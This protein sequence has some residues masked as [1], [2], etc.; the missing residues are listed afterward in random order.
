MKIGIMTFWESQNNYG[1]IL[2]ILALQTFLEQNG[3]EAFVIRYKRSASVAKK[4][5]ILQK[6]K[7]FDVQ[8]FISNR[9]HKSKRAYEA[10][11][12]PRKFDAFKAQYLKFGDTEYK[13]LGQ[14]VETPP[15][16]DVYISGSDQVWNN[17]FSVSCEAFLLGF[18]AAKTKRLSYAASFGKRELDAGTVQ[19]FEQYIHKF[20]GISVR[21]K[22]G[23]DICNRLGVNNSVWVP[24]P[25]LLFNKEEWL[26][27]LS[28]Q[29]EG[30]NQKDGNVLLYTLGNSP[31]KSKGK[32]VQY[33]KDVAGENVI[34]VS[35]NEDFAGAHYLTIQE[36]V[37]SIHKSDFIITNSF[38]G[39]VFCIIF[40]KNF[41][42]LPNTGTASGMNERIESLLGK[43][44]MTDHLMY[45]YSKEGLDAMR[46]KTI[47]WD[48]TNAS[49]RSWRSEAVAYLR[50][51]L[52]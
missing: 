16:A 21:E 41:V 26:K 7:T 42:V 27:I 32:Y 22:S 1:Q 10:Q 9:R 46:N 31:I 19:L 29:T 40:N 44:G 28:V 25:T 14:L 39:A 23:L 37:E 51:N 6:F 11:V 33:A 49:I 34:H 48:T 20:D 24:D 8:R 30:G 13:S 43:I 4:K 45:S 18:G 5:S 50:N 3:H 36:W 17:S 35:A 2:Q 12:K 15:E 52:K 38:H 47:D